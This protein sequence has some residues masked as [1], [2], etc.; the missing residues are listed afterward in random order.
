[1]L[2]SAQSL[3]DRIVNEAKEKSEEI[4]HNAEKSIIAITE[5]EKE[6]SENFELK[7]QARKEA[8]EKELDETVKEAQLK[9][10]ALTAAANDSVARQQMLFDKLK[11]Q[12]AAFKNAVT[13]KYKEH[14]ELLDQIP[15]NVPGD[16]QYFAKVMNAQLENMPDIG[17]YI[18]TGAAPTAEPLQAAM[19]EAPKNVA[20]VENVKPVH[21]GFVIE[22]IN[23]NS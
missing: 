1:M 16:P 7:A 14:I 15:D 21:D 23:S 17:K 2:I 20:P 12:I 6:L 8:L 3:A 13:L 22:D 4:I 11:L 18:Q 9:A 10:D 19:A 5:K